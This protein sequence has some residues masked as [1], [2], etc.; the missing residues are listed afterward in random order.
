LRIDYTD[1]AKATLAQACLESERI[2]SLLAPNTLLSADEM[3]RKGVALVHR[4]EI[5]DVNASRAKE[6]LSQYG[7]LEST[8]AE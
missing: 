8:V 6:I 4:L 7:Y 1:I 5:P 2:R 3:I